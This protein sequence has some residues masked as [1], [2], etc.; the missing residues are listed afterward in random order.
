MLPDP[1]GDTPSELIR[2][3]LQSD[4]PPLVRAILHQELSNGWGEHRRLVEHELGRLDDDTKALRESV[5]SVRES[6]TELN[7]CAKNIH[8]DVERVESA[9]KDYTKELTE[10]RIAHAKA[11]GIWGALAALILVV[12]VEIA[13]SLITR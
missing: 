3:I 12:V 13:K 1:T 8:R 5:V 10:V 2:R 11:G 9:G 6:V 7:A 4:V